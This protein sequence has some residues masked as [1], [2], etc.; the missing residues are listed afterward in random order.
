MTGSQQ[1][2]LEDG[3]RLLEAALAL[4]R[5]HTAA[6]EMEAM[7]ELPR[8]MQYLLRVANGEEEA[9]SSA[10]RQTGAPERE[11]R[12]AAIGFIEKLAFS[13]GADAYQVL[14]L[15]PWAP[16]E[17][18]K[19]HYRLL[20][21]LF[22]PD[23][24]VAAK[25]VAAE[26][27]ARINQAYTALSKGGSAPAAQPAPSSEN[28]AGSRAGSPRYFS[29]QKRVAPAPVDAGF[30]LDDLFARLTPQIVLGVVS[31]MAVILVAGVYLTNREPASGPMLQAQSSMPNA[32][33]VP[34]AGEAGN[35]KKL[36]QLLGNLPQPMQ[37]ATSSPPLKDSPVQKPTEAAPTPTPPLPSHAA[38]K[39][40]VTLPSPAGPKPAA[41]VSSSARALPS[42]AA[43]TRTPTEVTANPKTPLNLTPESSPTHESTANFAGDDGAKVS[44]GDGTP[45]AQEAGS[46]DHLASLS[47]PVGSLPAKTP[48]VGHEPT[49]D[50]L[51]QVVAQFIGSYN[52]GDLEGFMALMSDNIHT[53]E[54][55]GKAGIKGAYGRL[56][57]GSLARE[58][59]LRNLH[60]QPKD[61]GV[62]GLTDYRIT[63]LRPGDEASRL[64]TGSFKIEIAKLDGRALITGFYHRPDPK[65]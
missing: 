51:H 54:Q 4:H 3:T 29:V 5:N 33:L 28:A 22:H 50:E 52:Q 21:R 43:T 31:L 17:H 11:M 42:I 58:M 57:S 46:I 49:D 41:P 30:G 23:R 64:Y 10:L 1:E 8:D 13:P 48:T 62:L 9:L 12:Q 44:A 6:N 56:F 38:E 25:S 60:W 45:K 63:V 15:N 16:Q 47:A 65:R 34:E 24:G 2:Q 55:G 20:I 36:D 27:A 32:P 35:R 39:M 37:V 18:I 14:C 53:D 40:Q 19:L 61:E 59:V 7:S 26:Y